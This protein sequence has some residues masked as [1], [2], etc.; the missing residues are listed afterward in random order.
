MSL[1]SRLRISIVALVVGVVLAL[2]ALNLY[3][4]ATAKFS[5]L[6]ERATATAQQ[7]QTMLVTRLA[8]QTTGLPAP[9]TLEE[10][11]AQWTAIVREDGQFAQLL[12]DT[13]ASSR[14]VLE[15]QVAGESGR[16]L[17]SSDPA[18]V[19][20]PAKLLP[21]LANW[22]QEGQ[23]RQL[24]DL[25]RNQQDY[26][27]VMPLGVPEQAA[28]VFRIRVIYSSVLLRNT[29][30][31]LVQ[32]LAI[33]LSISFL[34]AVSLAFLA[35]HIAFRPLARVRDAIDRIAQGESPLLSSSGREEPKEMAALEGK[36]QVLGQQFRG[37]R[38]DAV[39]L[40]GNIEQLLERLEEAV[41]LFDRDDRLIMA[42]RAVE[43]ILGRGRWELMGR[44]LQDLFPPSTSLGAAGQLTCVVAVWMPKESRSATGTTN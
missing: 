8:Q 40:R 26:A 42:G 4:V 30:A 35:S 37:A 21:N 1:K 10:T 25:F 23:W 9:A 38:Q 5:D 29:L 18:A 28:P 13:L 43:G 34:A 44:S 16:V 14:T 27:V 32:Q 33:A 19:G 22:T 6:T 20:S 3:S 12:Q 31:P 7:V 17:A 11:K 41:L 2:A 24:L 36:L 39:E 15:I